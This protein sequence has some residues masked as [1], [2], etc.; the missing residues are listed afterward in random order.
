[1]SS[2][3]RT[4]DFADGVLSRE[5]V[6]RTPSGK[7][8]K[9]SSR[10]MVSL[11]QRHLAVM[12]FEVTLLTGTPRSP[13][14]R[15]CSTGRTGATS[16]TCGPRRWARAWTP[17]RPATSPSGARAAGALRGRPAGLLGY[18]TASSGMT[19]AVAVDHTIETENEYEELDRADPRP[20]QEDLPHRRAGGRAIRITKVVDVPHV[21]GC[22]RARADRPLR[23]HAHAR[24]GPGR[25]PGVRRAARVAGRSSGRDADVEV[26]ASPRSSRPSAGTCSRSPRRRPAPRA[27]RDPGQG[28]HRLGLRGPLLLGHR[29]LRPAVPDLH[30]PVGGPR[31]CCGSATRCCR[32]ARQRARELAQRGALFPW[33]TI[34]GE[35]ASAYYAAGT[36]QYHI[37]ADISYALPVRRAPPA[38]SSS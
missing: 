27:R 33:R 10:R 31:R 16:T 28:G 14:P 29:D 18:R 23:P 37:D 9:V 38:T 7:R 35:E 20:R 2:Y 19:L 21:A 4:L 24:P 5:L 1:M 12:T 25:R 15:R 17:V 13:S 22:A 32:A 26:P 36:A 34:N 8:V 11:T 3:E 30:E 6:W